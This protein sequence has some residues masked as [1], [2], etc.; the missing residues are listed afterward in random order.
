[1]LTVDF[2]YFDLQSGHVL[3]D[4]GC[5]EGRHSLTAYRA[6]GVTVLGFD[7]A[8]GDLQTAQSRIADM[9]PYHPCG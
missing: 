6:E 9:A 5:G 3:V 4:L 8:Y 7:L 2:D 1:M